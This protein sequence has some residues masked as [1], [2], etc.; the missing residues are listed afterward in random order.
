M[1][2]DYVAEAIEFATQVPPERAGKDVLAIYNGIR[3]WASRLDT[4]ATDSLW[5]FRPSMLYPNGRKPVLELVPLEEGLPNN[6]VMHAN[7]LWRWI[8]GTED[9]G[10]ALKVLSAARVEFARSQFHST[11]WLCFFRANKGVIARDDQARLELDPASEYPT[12]RNWRDADAIAREPVPQWWCA[13]SA[14]FDFIDWLS[15]VT[16]VAATPAHEVREP[17]SLIDPRPSRSELLS[18]IALSW[19][20]EAACCPSRALS[21]LAEA[22]EANRETGFLSGWD[23]HEEFASEEEV[24][25]DSSVKSFAQ[26]G[27]EARHAAN[28]AA[29]VQAIALYHS[30][31]YPSKDKAAE[32]IAP[33][34]GVA[35]RTVRDWL[36]GK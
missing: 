20:D 32:A 7:A 9:M 17:A 5:A 22:A 33:I 19:I 30:G 13:Q 2:V 10:R 23:S 29:R 6:L 34:L 8:G 36:K 25:E 24:R 31:G 4:Q 3:N 28:R 26:R 11:L 35:F 16:E 14:A 12:S 1:R 18:A 27:A 21:L 15:R